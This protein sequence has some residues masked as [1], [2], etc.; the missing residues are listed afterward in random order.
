VFIQHESC[1]A[2]SVEQ[3]RSAGILGSAALACTRQPPRD[4]ERVDS[5]SGEIV[6][7]WTQ[8]LHPDW[9]QLEQAFESWFE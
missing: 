5:L 1:A 8:R 7:I 3:G 9:S 4:F 2:R 6:P